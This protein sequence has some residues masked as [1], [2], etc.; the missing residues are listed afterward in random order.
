MKHTF[1]TATE[2]KNTSGAVLDQARKTPVGVTK[3]GGL[4]HVVMDMDTY[5]TLAP[6]AA[7]A[8]KAAARKAEIE[9]LME[10]G[11]EQ[12]GKVFEHLAK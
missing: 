3:H 6:E 12:F 10:E 5:E 11:H 7:A 4:S 2:L 1:V 9:A 8:A